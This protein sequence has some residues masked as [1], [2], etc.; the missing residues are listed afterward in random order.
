MIFAIRCFRLMELPGDN[1]KMSTFNRF[2]VDIFAAG[3]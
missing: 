1:A 2:S 3:G